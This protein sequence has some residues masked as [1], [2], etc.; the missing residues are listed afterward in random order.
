[1][2]RYI[3][4]TEPLVVV[5]SP[6]CT[7]GGGWAS[8]NS[9]VAAETHQSGL[10]ES[11]KLSRLC[12][13]VALSQ[14]ERDRHFVSELPK[15]N[16]LYRLREWYEVAQ[17][18]M[19]WAFMD[20]CMVGLREFKGKPLKKSE[21]IW[22]SHEVLI[23]KL[24]PF[25]CDSSPEHGECA[26]CETSRNQTWTWRFCPLLTDGMAEPIWFLELGFGKFILYYSSST[27]SLAAP[28]VE[29]VDDF[30]RCPACRGHRV[31]TLLAQTRVP[32][33]CQY[34]L[35]VPVKYN[36]SAC[37]GASGRLDPRHTYDMDCR[38][39]PSADGGV[40][41][42]IRDLLSA[43][44]LPRAVTD[45]AQG[46]V[47]TRSVCREWQRHG[48]KP[49]ASISL[50]TSFS[51]GLQFDP[52]LLEDGTVVHLNYPCINWAQE[53]FMKKRKEPLRQQYHRNRGPS[54]EEGLK[55]TAEEIPDESSLALN[56]IVSVQGSTPYAALLGRVTNVHRGL[57]GA[58][59][60]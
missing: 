33:E 56:F 24:R 49:I 60:A 18:E 20:M 19:T 28:A 32:H 41:E 17:R 59:H 16:S 40:K 39:G 58:S 7:A 45:D 6:R 43:A 4:A 31:K 44:G 25:V 2:L 48:N 55:V 52:L 23:S 42:R 50:T 29:V 9:I 15:G 22:A 57:T 5:M 34:P 53:V 8:I 37:E 14:L 35:D 47:G 36:H 12:A 11:Q 26:G 13:T 38:L 3:E 1:M 30:S 46:V 54:R 10:N 51:K 21:E 27:S